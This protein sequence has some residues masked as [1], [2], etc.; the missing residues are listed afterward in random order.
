MPGREDQTWLNATPRARESHTAAALPAR[1]RRARGGGRGDKKDYSL[2]N[3]TTRG[4]RHAAELHLEG[5]EMYFAGHARPAF[6][7]G[8]ASKHAEMQTPPSPRRPTSAS[9]QISDRKPAALTSSSALIGKLVRRSSFL[10]I[11]LPPRFCTDRQARNPIVTTYYR[12]TFAMLQTLFSFPLLACAPHSR[13]R[14]PQ[15]S[16]RLIKSRM[17]PVPSEVTKKRRMS[18]LDQRRTPDSRA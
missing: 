2:H 18:S 16:L 5:K 13:E 4:S 3:T 7:K 11:T 6:V 14:A 17:G 1:K 9:S 12:A 15:T 8:T 10:Y